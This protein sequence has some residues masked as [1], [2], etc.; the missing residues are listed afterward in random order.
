MIIG[1]ISVKSIISKSGIYGI[2]YSINPYYGCAHGCTYCYARFV[3]TIKGGDPRE[4]GSFVYVKKNAINLL[5]REIYNIDRGSILISSVTDPYQALEKKYMIT[6]G[7]LTILLKRQFP[8]V[9]LTKSDLILR[10]IDLLKRFN[11]LEAGLTITTLDERIKSIFEPR[12]PSIRSRLRALRI[13]SQR[14]INTYGFIA[15][16][17]PILQERELEN[18]V[19]TIAEM[20]VQRILVDKLNLKSKNWIT[21]QD[22]L[23]DFPKPKV[24]EFW[25]KLK[26]PSYWSRTK[27]LL[28]EISNKN[29]I[30]IDFC[31]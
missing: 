11:N 23:R 30:T 5:K 16:I 31:Y 14:G 4:W 17:L 19:L 12:A 24:R 21:L 13:L 6:R 10:D 25:K 28:L 29:K 22:A 18:L 8:V 15:P 9:I 27:K 7:I 2:K 20:G 3:H 1:E 26:D